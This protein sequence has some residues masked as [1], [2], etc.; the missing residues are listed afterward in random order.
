MRSFA[1]L[2]LVLA[3][4]ASFFVFRQPVVKSGPVNSAEAISEVK[5]GFMR[6]AAS[7]VSEKVS[8]FSSKPAFPG[9]KPGDPA[10]ERVLFVSD[11]Q[12]V[13]ERAAG[14]VHE[15][16][17]PAAVSAVPVPTPSLAFDGITN[18]QNGENFGLFF[19]PSD[20]NG[21]AGQSHYVQATNSL[22]QIFN[23]SGVAVAPPFKMSDIFA[24]L[25]TVCS[26]RN[27]G[28]P[29]VLYDTLADRWLLSSFCSA[30]P[31]FRQMIAISKTGDPTGAYFIY[32]FV[33]PSN[34]LNDY[35]KFGVWPDGY[36]M[37]ADE[38]IGSDYAGTAA[39]AFDRQK[40]LAGD[41]AAGYIYFNFPSASLI[42]TGGILPS[43]LD[44]YNPPPAGAP[45]IFTGYTSNDYGDPLDAMRLFEFHA[46]FQ[47]PVPT[48][49][50]GYPAALARRDARFAERPADVPRSVPQFRHP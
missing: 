20:T 32:E 5:P 24:P 18:R 10:Q 43:D 38:F 36:Y 19:L 3:V 9:R 28:E 25:G 48:G 33:M 17:A 13:R 7:G 37:S 40:M 1:V 27:D 50:L 30:F 26:T 14:S 41:P 31:P 6:A 49:T 45:N 39:L 15:D 22:V 11:N 2:F 23:K 46:D 47:D 8:S 12:A 4:G 34:R 29:I 21:D 16:D 44:G 42:R 35:A